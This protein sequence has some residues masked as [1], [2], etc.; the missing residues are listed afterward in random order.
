MKLMRKFRKE[1]GAFTVLTAILLTVLVGFL[2]LSIDVGYHYYRRA[3]LQNAADA[4]ATAVASN[5]GT[6]DTKYEDIAYQYLEKNGF[7]HYDKNGKAKVHCLVEAKGETTYETIATEDYIRS[8]YYKLTVEA[9]DNTFFGSILDINTL[10][11]RAVSYVKADA[12][13]VKMPK[14]LNYTVFAGSTDGTKQNPA[15]AING[16]TGGIVNTITGFAQD[17]FNALNN[18]IVKPLQSL[19]FSFPSWRPSTWSIGWDSEGANSEN[20]KF[21]TSKLTTSGDVH[22]NSNIAV[23]IAS[24]NANRIQDTDFDHSVSVEKLAETFS[25][26]PI[27]DIA[28]SF[29]DYGQVTFDAVNEITF[30]PPSG[31]SLTGEGGRINTYYYVQN[32]Q[33]I[34]QTQLT[35]HVINAISDFTPL[36]TQSAFQAAYEEAA[37]TYLYN[38]IIT[39]EQKDAV[40]Y[41]VRDGNLTYDPGT[42][43]FTLNNQ[44]NIIYSVNA[45]MANAALDEVES[46]GFNKLLFGKNDIT[47]VNESQYSLGIAVTGNDVL[48]KDD[49]DKIPYYSIRNHTNTHGFGDM[50]TGDEY[51][52]RGDLTESTTFYKLN[53]AG[54]EFVYTANG[55]AVERAKM[56]INGYV[57]NREYQDFSKGGITAL[58]KTVAGAN[59]AIA[60]TFIENSEYIDIPNL[61]PYFVRQI[62]RSIKQATRV[63]EKINDSS[64]GQPTIRHAANER[65]T[66]LEGYKSNLVFEDNS[67]ADSGIYNDKNKTVLFKTFKRS[68]Y[69]GLTNLQG[70]SAPIEFS[71]TNIDGSEYTVTMSETTYKGYQLYDSNN[72]LRKP[73][74]FVESFKTE[75]VV[76]S[77]KYGSKAVEKFKNQTAQS[78]IDKVA[79]KK[80]QLLDTYKYHEKLTD[81]T[82]E[83]NNYTEPEMQTTATNDEVTQKVFKGS[84]TDEFVNTNGESRTINVPGNSASFKEAQTVFLNGSSADN[85]IDKQ[86]DNGVATAT[87]D[88]AYPAWESLVP[89]NL[90][91]K[92]N[93]YKNTTAAA[94]ITKET[95]PSQGG[96]TY[97]N[98]NSDSPDHLIRCDVDGVVNEPWS[99]GDYH[100]VL[101]PG[102]TQAESRSRTWPWQDW[103]YSYKTGVDGDNY[104][105]YSGSRDNAKGFVVRS[106]SG[107][108][109]TGKLRSSDN[110]DFHILSSGTLLVGP[111][112]DTYDL[113]TSK[114]KITVDNNGKL[115]VNGGVYLNGEFQIRN[116]CVVFI[117]GPLNDAADQDILVGEGSVLIVKGDVNMKD[118]LKLSKNALCIIE[119]D[120]ILNDTNTDIDVAEGALLLIKGKIGTDTVETID[121]ITKIGKKG[122]QITVSDGG[123]LICTSTNGILAPANGNNHKGQ[124]LIGNNAVVYSADKADASEITLGNN[125]KLYAKG[126]I[127]AGNASGGLQVGTNAT[128][129]ANYLRNCYF[130]GTSNDGTIHTVA[131]LSFNGNFTNS[132]TL[133]SD[134]E[135][136]IGGTLT[137]TS[138]GEIISTGKATFNGLV[139]SG[140]IVCKSQLAVSGNLENKNSTGKMYV[141]GDTNIGGTL[142]ATGGSTFYSRANVYASNSSG[143]DILEL[144][145]ATKV[146]VKGVLSSNGSNKHIWMH[147]TNNENAL[148]SVYGN[149]ASDA[150]GGKLSQFCNATTGSVYLNKGFTINDDSTNNYGIHNNGTMIVNGSVTVNGSK[151]IRLHDEYNDSGSRY[152]AGSKITYIGGSL[153][154]GNCDL[155]IKH[156]RK[157]YTTDAISVR[158]I[159]LNDAYAHTDKSFSASLTSEAAVILNNNSILDVL[160]GYIATRDEVD[161]TSDL[162]VSKKVEISTSDPNFSNTGHANDLEGQQTANSLTLTGVQL[163]IVN[164]GLTLNN[165]SGTLTLT[166]SILYMQGNLLC[167]EIILNNA[168]LVVDGDI[169]CTK[170]TASNNS[171]LVCKSNLNCSGDIIAQGGSLN[172]GSDIKVKG[173]ITCKNIT[174]TDNSKIWGCNALNIATLQHDYDSNVIGHQ[175]N[176]RYTE[177]VIFIS[178][179]ASEVFCGKNSANGGKTFYISTSGSFYSPANNQIYLEYCEVNTSGL[180][181]IGAETETK[182]NNKTYANTKSVEFIKGF[183]ENTTLGYNTYKQTNKNTFLMR[184]NGIFYNDGLS[185]PNDIKLANAGKLYLVG[186]V[187]INNIARDGSEDAVDISFVDG[188]ETYIGKV[189]GGQSYSGIDTVNASQAIT[190]RSTSAGTIYWQGYYEG[191]GD[192]YFENNLLI[193]GWCTNH[194]DNV[195]V[196]KNVDMAVYIPNGHTYVDGY[197]NTVV[198]PRNC[199]ALHIRPTAGLYVKGNLTVGSTVRNCGDLFIRDKLLIATQRMKKDKSGSGDYEFN[200]QITDTKESDKHLGISIKNGDTE[201]ITGNSARLYIGSTDNLDFYGDVRNYGQIYLNAAKVRVQGYNKVAGMNTDVFDKDVVAWCN[202]AGAQAY[203]AGKVELCSNMLVNKWPVDTGSYYSDAIFSCDGKLT[204]GGAA[205]NCGKLI[206]GG[207]LTNVEASSETVDG[208]QSFFNVQD[209]MSLMNGIIEVDTASTTTVNPDAVLY[210]GGDVLLGMY[211]EGDSSTKSGS[212]MSSGT[213]YIAG[214]LIINTNGPYLSFSN[215]WSDLT[216]NFSFDKLNINNIIELIVK[217]SYSRSFYRTGLWLLPNSNTFVGNKDISYINQPINLRSSSYVTSADGTYVGAGGVIGENAIFMTGGDFRT[218]RATKIGEYCYFDTNTFGVKLLNHDKKTSG[219]YNSAYVYVED[220][221]LCDTIGS[222]TNS[223]DIAGLLKKICDEN[224]TINSIVTTFISQED[225]DRLPSY[226]QNCSR[227]LDIMANSNVYVGG[228]IYAN[229]RFEVR[230]N[231]MVMAACKPGTGFYDSS[232]EILQ[233]IVKPNG[234]ALISIGNYDFFKNYSLPE[235]EDNARQIEMY[236]R[237]QKAKNLTPG[238]YV[239]QSMDI[240]PCSKIV[241]NGSSA[242]Y[243]TAK[244]R[245]MVKYYSNGSFECGR[246]VE[247][248]KALNGKD[249]SDD[250]TGYDQ[251][252]ILDYNSSKEEVIAKTNMWCNN[253][254]CKHKIHVGTGAGFT[255]PSRC[256]VCGTGNFVLCPADEQ[257]Y[258][259]LTRAETQ[260]LN[261]NEA[262]EKQYIKDYS[263]ANSTYMY[264]GGDFISGHAFGSTSFLDNAIENVASWFR[265]EFLSTGYLKIYASSTLRAKGSVT[266]NRYITLRHDA[267]IYSGGDLTAATSIEGGSYS[268]FYVAGNMQAASSATTKFVDTIMGLFNLTARG[269]IELRDQT[270]AIVCGNMYSSASIDIGEQP[271]NSYMRGRKDIFTVSAGEGFETTALKISD[272]Q[273]EIVNDDDNNTGSDGDTTQNND[274]DEPDPNAGVVDPNSRVDTNNGLDS[275]DEPNTYGAEIFVQGKMVALNGHIKEYAYTNCV[276]GDYVY[277]PDYITLRSN[278]DLWVLPEAFGNETQHVLPYTPRD[279]NNIFD[280]ILELVDRLKYDLSNLQFTSGSVYTFG[281]VTVNKNASMMGTKDFI[282]LGSLDTTSSG[283][284]YSLFGTLMP[285]QMVMREDSLVL[286]GRNI[287]ITALPAALNGD[288]LNGTVSYAGFDSKGNAKYPAYRYYCS[289]PNNNVHKGYSYTMTTE[290]RITNS[291]N[292]VCDACGAMLKQ[293]PTTGGP[294]VKTVQMSHPA[295][296]YAGNS[297]HIYTMIDM[298]MTYLIADQGELRIDNLRTLTDYQNTNLKELPNAICSYNKNIVLNSLVGQLA[299]L[300]YAPNGDIKFDGVYNDIYGSVI[301]NTVTMDAFYQNFHRFHNWRTMDLHIAESGSVYII[302]ENTWKQAP[303]LGG[304]YDLTSGS[305]YKDSPYGVQ[306]FF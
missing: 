280:Y 122:T 116:N 207:S 153:S 112:S 135:V 115:I 197:V 37:D 76:N 203:I 87:S 295:V 274:L 4:A 294:L 117:D 237:R 39:D 22:S 142:I 47:D 120:M 7:P 216:S 185:Y 180:V 138:T 247:V 31:L 99:N 64:A 150:F 159:T 293:N 284:F 54:D 282:F 29:D 239:Y 255:I 276:V 306:I 221:F 33:Y 304:V 94:L 287:S 170:V 195:G 182:H 21:N 145:G 84:S 271:D 220:D 292:L 213:T 305:Q 49:V 3:Q 78:A 151:E 250:T 121:G 105:Q 88:D 209:H 164:G 18:W 283:N 232:G 98:S 190:S 178:G 26:T 188:S 245:D 140:T 124:L 275:D 160:G 63:K 161:T 155:I 12:V 298:L 288:V 32:Q 243:T 219:A 268:E 223:A 75:E 58:D 273:E 261:Y 9:E 158:K 214:K 173:T 62:N 128:I 228:A 25:V 251:T 71:A 91:S 13:Y 202:F 241:V 103:T 100:R 248:G 242:V 200:D 46:K 264:V 104:W 301:G 136:V 147:D 225:I 96:H 10:G 258:M 16:Q 106:N 48:Y 143:T 19:T 139:N 230:E 217:N 192:V 229:A 169:T 79:T 193:N 89:S 1:S 278:S 181:L 269:R 24:V 56:N 144:T 238:L 35:L 90:T 297:M 172:H 109:Y 73:L 68:S 83:V 55:E 279:V 233:T 302:N 174:A 256:P 134:N 23:N 30:T 52:K 167:G 198:H 215:Y 70:L 194:D 67:Y 131:T 72:E 263:F 189:T 123:T 196:S 133:F 86:Y 101:E 152:N 129:Y 290:E 137:N 199:N 108:R 38:K 114:G 204:F 285:R 11:M 42:L 6:I 36:T 65:K 224:S 82:Q 17:T 208:R 110:K 168:T 252:G 113:D 262:K 246:Y 50:T 249:E 59:F 34:E 45:D 148:L 184:S 201:N 270:R 97:R 28:P 14:A 227:C 177:G 231:S 166:N 126:Y 266:S 130:A 107:V 191:H 218:K 171:L 234:N 141:N 102:E 257:E 254:N 8:G 43:T 127:E 44:A 165:G 236:L 61:K 95:T 303:E 175:S 212:F 222:T 85:S 154:A 260:A 206:V 146:Y 265:N 211:E 27:E 74:D 118:D 277:A 281:S 149:G 176:F 253:P 157:L 156:Q 69:S 286:F 93:T 81:V 40:K 132:G 240:M 111:A 125:A 291:E 186:N 299:S 162:N 267:K 179:N 53:E 272:Y 259:F 20:F 226:P 51:D 205:Y 187:N 210:C 5:L 92:Y 296:M 119:G 66:T 57:I 77:D 300:F 80:Q 244:I 60:R 183:E 235:K 289:Q 41:M 15:I 2:A 163:K